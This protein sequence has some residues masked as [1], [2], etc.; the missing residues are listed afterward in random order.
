[1][2]DLEWLRPKDSSHIQKLRIEVVSKRWQ[3]VDQE[4]IRRIEALRFLI[5]E[6]NQVI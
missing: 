6:K 2:K 1:M 4:L 5:S 3:L